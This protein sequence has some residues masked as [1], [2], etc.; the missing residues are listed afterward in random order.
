M[1]Y[2][3]RNNNLKN[4]KNNLDFIVWIII[5]TKPDF[6][7]YQ[8]IMVKR[9][10]GKGMLFVMMIGLIFWWITKAD[11]TTK[12]LFGMSCDVTRIPVSWIPTKTTFDPSQYTGELEA[13]TKKWYNRIDLIKEF[14]HG[15]HMIKVL[16]G[17]KCD[18]PVSQN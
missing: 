2:D 15:D 12:T 6:Y 7:L 9:L 10:L 13:L 3:I 16:L 4:T 11:T 1:V 17:E 14:I 5:K 8:K 18:L